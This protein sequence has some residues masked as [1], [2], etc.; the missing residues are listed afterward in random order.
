VF[1]LFDPGLGSLVG[2]ILAG[3]GDRCLAEIDGRPLLAHVIARLGR[4]VDLVVIASDPP[5][6]RFAGF[7]LPLIADTAAAVSGPLTGIHAALA[8]T[9][10]N[11]PRARGILTAP[12]DAASLPGDLAARIASGPADAIGVAKRGDALQPLYAYWPMAFEGLLAERLAA[13]EDRVKPVIEASPHRV[14]AFDEGADPFADALA[15]APR[16][17]G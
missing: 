6:D 16:G 2:A 17:G 7:G 9:R 1:R 4:Q 14:V 11:A 13:G 12:A 3:G 8:W 10:L 15:C 5:L